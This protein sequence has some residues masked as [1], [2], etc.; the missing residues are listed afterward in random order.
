[1]R[2]IPEAH[3]LILGSGPYE[4]NLY[5]L[6]RHLGVSDRVS[7]KHVA[8]ADRQSMATAL[9]ESS[10]VAALSDYEAHPVAVME[11]LCVARP[12]VG[13]DIAGIG[14]LV[15]EGWVRGVPRGAPAAAV[16]QELVKAM[17]SP[18]LVD[19]A[20]LPSWDSCADQ[21]AHVYLSSLG[22][23][24][25]SRTLRTRD[26]AASLICDGPGGCSSRRTTLRDFPGFAA[27]RCLPVPGTR[28]IWNA[29]PWPTGATFSPAWSARLRAS[30]CGVKVLQ[31]LS[32]HDIP[33]QGRC[34]S[35]SPCR[36]IHDFPDSTNGP[37]TGPSQRD[38]CRHSWPVSRSGLPYVQ[39]TRASRVRRA[40]AHAVAH[41]SIAGSGLFSPNPVLQVSPFYPGLEL[42]T[43]VGIRLTGLPVVLA[44]SLVILLCRLLLVLIIYHAA[45]LVSP[46]RRGASLVVAFYA[47]SSEFYSFNSGFAY[48][49]LALTLG[50][51]GIFLLRRAQLADRRRSPPAFPYCVA[52]ADRHRG[53]SPRHKLDGA[54]VPHC[55][56]GDEPEGRTQTPRSCRGSNGSC[57]CHLDRSPRGAS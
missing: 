13:Y 40:S 11:A 47:V 53:H 22:I 7:I 51:G 31:W 29:A 45:L 18:S 46:S 32:P 10:V 49:T 54:S 38:Y 37:A 55:L 6:A 4:S 16:A 35:L 41:E 27:G 5:E 15:A 48:E 2:E 36:S 9:A 50:L 56:G 33:R 8:P 19:H 57:R 3:L 43:G 30:A 28:S 23:A 44:E 12:V 25:E 20:Q 34:C 1:M 17:S 14:E 24:P 39:P 21:L 42:F 52:G 26:A